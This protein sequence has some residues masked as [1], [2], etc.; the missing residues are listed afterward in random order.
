L[1]K[2]VLEEIL[3]VISQQPCQFLDLNQVLNVA[4]IELRRFLGTDRVVVSRFDSDWNGLIVAESVSFDEFSIIGRTVYDPCFEL[5]WQKQY[6]QGRINIIEDIETANIQICYQEFLKSLQIQANLVLPVMCGESLW[7]LLAVHQCSA[8]RSWG[9]QEIDLVQHVVALINMLV[10]QAKL[11]QEVQQLS[12]N[13]ERQVQDRTIRLR[14]SLEFELLLKH[15]V[16][17]I[18]SS[19]EENQIF[20]TVTQELVLGLSLVCCRVGLYDANKTFCTI[21]HEYTTT[22]FSY[23]GQT[24]QIVETPAFEVHQQL[25]QGI[26]SQF[27]LITDGLFQGQST[28][29]SLACP[30][31][32]NANVFGNLWLFKP[33]VQSFNEWELRLVQE[34]A[35]QCAIAIHQARRFQA[36]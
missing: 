1:P 11:Q 7:G 10:W 31:V 21:C 33:K 29:T 12:L 16:N 22:R 26:T 27:C 15:I 17:Q 23:Q 6:Q 13:L 28:F 8:P 30:L 4:V 25:F 3:K 19:L 14:R 35:T 18:R 32:D 2:A 36:T 24:F 9:T 5:Y 34:V 20:Q